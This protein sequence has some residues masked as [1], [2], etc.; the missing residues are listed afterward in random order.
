MTDYGDIDVDD[1]FTSNPVDDWISIKE[2]QNLA[3]VTIRELER[4]LKENRNGTGLQQFLEQR[5]T[6]IL[7]ASV[8]D[9]FEFADFLEENGSNDRGVHNRL[10][11]ASTFYAALM[12]MNQADSNPAGYVLSQ[13]DLDISSPDRNHHT[14]EEM[15]DFLKFIP[16]PQIQ[17]AALYSLKFGLRRGACSNTD[18]SCVHIDHPEYL[19]FLDEQGIELR[20]EV[21]DKPD[22]IY[23]Y[24]K[25]RE[26]DVVA[27]E[28]R[29]D[30]NK[31]VNEAVLPI[32]NELKHSLLQFMT[33]RPVTNPPHPLFP[34]LRRM[35]GEY[36]RMSGDALYNLLI[37]K[38]ATEYGIRG[39]DDREDLDFH[40]FRHF[41]ST[42]MSP[43]RGDHDGSLNDV[44][45]KYIRGDK[46][47]DE[48]QDV[49]DEV[50]RHDSWG[51]NIR[52]EY[53]NNIY[54]FNLF[55]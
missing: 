52:D 26:G 51:V 43:L 5:D 49:L 46:M 39:G 13:L 36:E 3:P 50:Y 38:Y 17:T 6:E 15:A 42:Q 10:S 35:D 40:Y 16:D 20:P 55:D 32:D 37:A 47:N 25:F 41:F 1:I 28:R 30:G 14:V 19:A 18:L 44:I 2:R 12:T 54:T 11:T 29:R 27:G 21:R 53:I 22:S 45:L 7:E 24:S 33:I 4:A 48:H 23:V 8:Q 9:F 31:R 34:A